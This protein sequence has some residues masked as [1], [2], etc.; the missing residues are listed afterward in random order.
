MRIHSVLTAHPTEAR[1]RA[2]TAALARIARHLD[3]HLDAELAVDER[4]E[5][6]RALREAIEV[7]WRTAPLRVTR[8]GPL[9]EVR[10]V[11]ASFDRTIFSVAPRL[12]RAAEVA[13]GHEPGTG[14]PPV[15]A[16]LRF[17]SWIGGDRDGNPFVT[18]SV[19]NQTLDLQ[20][21]HVLA[22]LEA[23]ATAVGSGLTADAAS[24]PPSPRL[25]RGSSPWVPGRPARGDLPCR[26]AR[27]G[28]DGGLRRPA[29][30]DLATRGDRRAAHGI[31]APEACRCHHRTGPG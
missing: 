29:G 31:P 11:M 12:Y 10:T 26:V 20:A 9:D 22:A 3:G 8:P 15:P 5:H 28:G 17:G 1:R 13:V 7:L 23:A 25:A 21:G 14:P 2:V 30:P 18:A 27:S 19:T 4:Q 6:L 24:T 16:F